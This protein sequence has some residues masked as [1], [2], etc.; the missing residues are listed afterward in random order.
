M[1][2]VAPKKLPSKSSEITPQWLA[3]VL[4]ECGLCQDN[5]VCKVDVDLISHG[6]GAM[7]QVL[8]LRL[9]WAKNQSHLPLSIA[10]KIPGSIEIITQ[11]FW[12]LM[13][14]EVKFYQQLA[15]HQD[16]FCPELYYAEL[17]AEAKQF[18][19]LLEDL[20]ELTPGDQVQ[21]CSMQQ[22]EMGVRYLARFHRMWWQNR[23]LDSYPWLGR[24]HMRKPQQDE[25]NWFLPRWRKFVDETADSYGFTAQEIRIGERIAA[26]ALQPNQLLGESHWTLVHGDFRPDNMFFDPSNPDREVVAH[27]WQCV[28]V[29]NGSWDLAYFLLSSLGPKRRKDA[30]RG[31]IRLY[32]SELTKNTAITY[33]FGQCMRDYRAS[34]LDIIKRNVFVATSSLMKSTEESDRMDDVIRELLRGS[35][36]AALDHRADE[37]LKE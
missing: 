30:E 9:D 13:Q 22:M 1:T 10:M 23:I 32:L 34:L 4:G 2:A 27:D 8:R 28:F 33:P 25:E 36:A 11:N 3:G 15:F 19:L 6:R 16:G 17:D 20:G 29:G 7:C 24:P 31:L 21:R 14:K 18:V 37:L 35:F 12:W 26:R 5:R